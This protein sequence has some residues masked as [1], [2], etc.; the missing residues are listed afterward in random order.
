MNKTNVIRGATAAWLIAAVIGFGWWTNSFFPLDHWLA[1]FWLRAWAGA[2]FFGISSLAAGTRLV[3]LFRLPFGTVGERFTIAFA[4]GVLTFALG[5]FLVGWIGLLGTVFFYAWPAVLLLVGGRTLARQCRHLF[6][7]LRRA[8]SRALSPVT[9]WQAISLAFLLVGTL[10]IYLQVLTPGNISFDA[11]WYHLPI[12]EGYAATG[13]IRPFPEGWYLAAYPHLA[14][15]LYAWAFLAPGGVPQHLCLVMHLEFVVFLAMIAGAAAF[16]RRLLG[17]PRLW[18]ASGAVFLFPTLFQYGPNLNGGADHVLGLWAAPL[19]LVLLRYLAS[20]A[21]RTATLLGAFLGAAALTKYQAI[22]W[23]PAMAVVL[24]VHAARTRSVRPL[25][26]AAATALVVSAPFWLKNLIAYGDPFYPNLHNHLRVHPFYAGAGEM[27]KQYYLG[28]SGGRTLL[29]RLRD[30]PLNALIFSFAPKTWGGGS[31]GGPTFGSLFTLLTPLAFVVRPRRRLLLVAACLYLSLMT[32]DFIYPEERYLQAVFGWMAAFVAAVLAGS[33]Q[34]GSR[35]VRVGLVLLVGLQL[36]WRSDTFFFRNHAMIG[37]API[38]AFVDYLSPTGEKPNS[39]RRYPGEDLAAIGAALPRGAHVVA[40]DLYQSM[41]SGVWL[42]VDNPWWEGGLEY[43]Q[44]DSPEQ[45]VATLRRFRATHVLWPEHTSR[46]P[47]DMGRDAVLAR[48][49]LTYGEQPLHVAGF[50]I[51]PLRPASADSR[52]PADRQLAASPTR[53]AWLTCAPNRGLGLYSP[54]GLGSG[55]PVAL[56][57][58]ARL[59]A[60]PNATLA[61]ANVALTRGGC[62]EADAARNVLSAQF[63]PVMEESGTTLWARA[64]LP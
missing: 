28:G 20:P 53:I 10:G 44:T 27:M 1:F 62:A 63:A 23:V 24:A 31:R 13:Q 15:W 48:T 33:W 30:A 52:R 25:L 46:P 5:I 6:G 41:G 42:V 3:E 14:S 22:Y 36:A 51:V 29:Q 8:G 38:K 34:M 49:T 32:W 12:A 7:A 17:R 18:G 60:D 37:D 11:R 40:H 50:E 2:L 45:T 19:G 39:D 59:K 64:R 54:T 47:E 55:T 56:L 61:G 4:L 9:R 16:A 26:V 57:D 43:L 35:A 21:A 58:A